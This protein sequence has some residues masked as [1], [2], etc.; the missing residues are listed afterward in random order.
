MTVEIKAPQ[1]Q[2]RLEEIL[3][4]K[5][6]S[7]NYL[8]AIMLAR[9]LRLPGERIRELQEKALKQMAFEYRNAIAVR[10]LAQEW[11]FSRTD[12]AD[13]LKNGLKEYEDISEKKRLEQAYDIS[14]CRYLTARQWVEQLLS[15]MK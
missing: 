2:A 9:T 5:I 14:S 7:K 3:Q 12:L 4:K 1:D 11:G 6:A 8:S 10:N 13:I 15:R